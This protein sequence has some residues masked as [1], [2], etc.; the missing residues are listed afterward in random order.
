MVQNWE[1][2]VTDERTGVWT[3]KQMDGWTDG[4]TRVISK[5]PVRITSSIKN[6]D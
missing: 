3:D 4:Q 1:K 2:L 6:K 5:D